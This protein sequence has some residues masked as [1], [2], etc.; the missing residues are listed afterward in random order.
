M[1]TK[2][3]YYSIV[4][5]MKALSAQVCEMWSF[6]N[7]YIIT[8][9]Y[10]QKTKFKVFSV[11]LTNLLTAGISGLCRNKEEITPFSVFLA[12]LEAVPK[13]RPSLLAN[14]LG[15]ESSSSSSPV[16]RPFLLDTAEAS[17]SESDESAFCL[18][19]L[20]SFLFLMRSVCQRR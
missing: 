15:G 5:V 20:I 1:K 4:N 17:A 8:L 13:E 3:F 14:F 10:L 9:V 2:G 11:S 7:L 16:G 12:P 19:N 6:Y 18:L